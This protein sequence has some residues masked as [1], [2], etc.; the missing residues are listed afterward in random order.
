MRVLYSHYLADDNHPAA[1]MVQAIARELGGLGHEVRIHR[2]LGPNRPDPIGVAVGPEGQRKERNPLVAAL[3]NRLWFARTL[4]SNRS[5]GRRDRATIAAF[6]PD[7]ILGREDAYRT[8]I[9]HEAQRTRIPLVTYADAPVA[10]EMRTF[11]TTR[12]WHPPKLVERIER[13]WLSQSRAVITPTNPGRAELERYGLNVPIHAISNG[14]DPDRFPRWT[15]GANARG[16]RHSAYLPT[17]SF[18]VTRVHSGTFMGSTFSASW[19]G[20]RRRGRVST[21]CLLARGPSDRS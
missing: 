6:R 11:H 5:I 1:R 19:S 2:C 9:V 4:A 12:R 13:S 20:R 16:G 15:N 8:S 18:W 3:K 7:V 17:R 21:G 10:Y 14:V